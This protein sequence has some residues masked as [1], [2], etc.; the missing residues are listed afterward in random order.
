MAFTTVSGHTD[1]P[2]VKPAIDT[3]VANDERF[4]TDAVGMAL[5]S[6]DR[7]EVMNDLVGNIRAAATAAGVTLTSLTRGDTTALT[8]IIQGFSRFWR[9][10]TVTSF[11]QLQLL[12]VSWFASH[13]KN[14]HF[15]RSTLESFIRC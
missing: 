8:K 1:Y 2:T 12:G 9:H 5:P 13:T 3:T 6:E 15:C 10:T 4:V 14:S 11:S 7:A